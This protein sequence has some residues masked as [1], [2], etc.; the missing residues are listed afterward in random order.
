MNKNIWGPNLWCTIH[1]T[2]AAYIPTADNKRAFK[3]FINSLTNIMPC[4]ECRQH[5]SENLQNLPPIERYMGSNREL[6]LWTYLL[7]DTVNRQLNKTS[8]TF[9]S[10]QERYFSKTEAPCPSCQL[11]KKTGWW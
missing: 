5:L 8:P 3:A 6:F 7:H 4:G 9:A 2:A 1:T 10:V 11:P